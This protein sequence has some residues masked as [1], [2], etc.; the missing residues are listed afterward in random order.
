METL[1]LLIYS[2][3]YFQDY[4]TLIE[5]VEFFLPYFVPLALFLFSISL[6]KFYINNTRDTSSNLPLPPGTV[7]F[8]FVGETI[9]MI[10]KVCRFKSLSWL[11]RNVFSA[12]LCIPCISP[13][14][15]LNSTFIY[16]PLMVIKR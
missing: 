14:F 7:G 11:R 9:S 13:C 8:P 10:A 12:I 2:I 16:N 1:Y 4:G 5:G 6:W 15:F 3:S